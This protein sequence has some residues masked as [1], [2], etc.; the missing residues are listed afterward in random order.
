MDDP[1]RAQLRANLALI[2]PGTA[3]RDGL[4]RIVHGRTGALI[5]L[6]HSPA[7]AAI[8]TGG[9]AIDVALS[10]T[11]LREL[12]KMDGAILLNSTLDRIVHAGV[13]LMPDA[14]VPTDEA[15]TR[16]RTA[17][18]V[19][20]LT[21]IPVLTVS[22]SMSSI[23]LFVNGR[24]HVVAR[25]EHSLVRADQALSTL[26]RY[27]DRLEEAATR[28]TVS[29]IQD[30]VTVRDVA[31]L[32]QRLEMVRRLQSEVDDHVLEL[33]VDGRLIKLQLQEL[34][35]GLGAL[36]VTLE[37]DYARDGKPLDL[38]ALGETDPDRLLDPAL[39]AEQ[40]GLAPFSSLDERLQARG[41]RQLARIGRLP[42]RTVERLV[43]RFGTL[44]GLFGASTAEL[45]DVDAVDLATALSIR[46][47]LAR[48]SESAFEARSGLPTS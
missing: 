9:F 12:A 4:E 46:E 26:S 22:A 35:A 31:L 10:A 33:G 40:I 15:G 30:T 8:S 19:S 3:L 39:V 18:R 43:E 23:A 34:I 45:V 29:E 37:R 7:L 14:L 21:G 6:G 2:A 1:Y 41:Y 32:A 42:V 44:Q 24:R 27:R 13:H 25:P 5:V 20:R 48:L 28:L 36:T 17:D 11:A 47:S 16:H 38:A